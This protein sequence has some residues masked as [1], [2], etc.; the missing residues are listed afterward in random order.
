MLEHGGKLR[1]AANRYSIPL[2]QWIDLST[3]VNPNGWPVPAVPDRVWRRLPE[4]EDDLAMVARDYYL[5]PALLPVAGSQAAIQMIPELRP[6]CRV[7]II[8]PGYGEH[9]AAWSR[10]GHHVHSLTAERIEDQII[11]LDVL[12]LIHPNNPTGACFGREQLLSWR[13]GLASRGGL[14][15][16]DEA[17]MDSTPQHTLA[18]D[19]GL[20]GLIVLRSLGKFFGLAGARVGFALA[21]VPLLEQLRERLGP[22]AVSGPSRWIACRALRDR[23]WQH[24]ARQQLA[25]QATRLARLLRDVGLEPTGGTTLFQWIITPEAGRIHHQLAQQG[26]LTRL[27]QGPGSLRVGIPANQAEFRRLEAAL[28]RTR[29]EGCAA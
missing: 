18:P 22:W 3:G 25:Q 13:Q 2:E 6:T 11:R 20:P 5:A 19:T 15:V 7:G 1:A 14:L 8:S 24:Q 12:V 9:A 4:E 29:R 17:F 26:I 27:F 16:V 10:A 28:Q 23:H 21:E